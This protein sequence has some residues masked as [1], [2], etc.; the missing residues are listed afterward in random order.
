MRVS[1]PETLL[2]VGAD[3]D[4]IAALSQVCKVILGTEVRTWPKGGAEPGDLP[5]VAGGVRGV[6]VL[7]DAPKVAVLRFGPPESGH[8][9]FLPSVK[10][11]GW[12]LAKSVPQ[13][14]AHSVPRGNVFPDHDRKVLD[15]GFSLEYLQTWFHG[16]KN[17]ACNQHAKQDC[18]RMAEWL[19]STEEPFLAPFSA[20]A[21]RARW[22]AYADQANQM[23]VSR[24]AN[25]LCVS[26]T[27]VI[28]PQEAF[29]KLATRYFEV[30]S[31]STD[32]AFARQF[33]RSVLSWKK[34]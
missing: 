13:A 34:E 20:F 22:D 1:D 23:T 19:A 30:A 3:S 31:A 28:Q 26:A 8:T 12:F 32:A 14:E 2:V 16:I 9:P 29:R 4:R 27:D 17:F 21:G 18:Q 7:D 33:R 11:W 5:K 6:W 25:L 24:L 10:A 15:S